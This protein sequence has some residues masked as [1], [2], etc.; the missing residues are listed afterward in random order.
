LVGKQIRQMGN[1]ERGGLSLVVRKGARLLSG[2]TGLAGSGCRGSENEETEGT[3][4]VSSP[5]RPSA[6]QYDVNLVIL[7]EDQDVV[8]VSKVLKPS[9]G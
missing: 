7:S 3:G 4:L 2:G 8:S 6:F 5:T 1:G 9:K